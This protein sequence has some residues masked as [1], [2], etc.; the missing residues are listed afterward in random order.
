[1]IVKIYIDDSRVVKMLI[2]EWMGELKD[3]EKEI[4][5]LE[6]NN[7]ED[8]WDKN[9]E[10]PIQSIKRGA[11]FF[12]LSVLTRIAFEM[13]TILQIIRRNNVV[14]TK[15]IDVLLICIDFLNSYFKR[16]YKKLQDISLSDDT[17]SKYFEFETN[18]K[19]SKLLNQIEEFY[20]NY[21]KENETERISIEAENGEIP[22]FSENIAD[23]L[24]INIK[25]QF[26]LENTEHIQE[27]ESNILIRLDSNEN[28]S[29]AIHEIFRI[30][31]SIKG[32]IGVYLS[33]LLPDNKHYNYLKNSKDV[34]HSF[35]N[36]LSLVREKKSNF[37]KNLI[38]LSL[39]V[40]DFMKLLINAILND[41]ISV[42]IDR[43][44]IDKI[45]DE[46]HYIQSLPVSLDKNNNT[47]S[48]ANEVGKAE[49]SKV[50]SNITQSIRVQQEK[51]DA[52]MNI[53]SE[54]VIAK[55][56]FAHISDKL[57][58]E[59]N[60]PEISKEINQLGSYVNRISD[61][62]Q[63][64]IMSIRMVEVKTVFQ[65][66][67][68]IIRDIAQNSGKKIDLIMEGEDTEIDKT[69]IEQISDPLV[70]IIRNSADHGI[71][72]SIERTKKNKSEIGKVIL[73]AY[74]KDKYVF[75]EVEDDGK[76]INP[77]DIKL[78]AIEK[79]IIT[80]YEGD[81]MTD[82]QII[83]LI[84]VPGFSTAKKITE[85]SGRGVGMDIVK[86]NIAKIKGTV[87][88]ESKVDKGAKMII[89]L[90]LSLAVSRGLMVEV[91]QKSYIIPIDN[92]VE[93]VKIGRNNIHK[94]KN[95][96]FTYLR[97]K[98][99][100]LEWLSQMFLLGEIDRDKDEYNAVIISNGLEDYAIIV[101]KLKNEQE[102]VMK[103][104][105]GHLSAIPGISGSTLLG[106]GQVVLILNPMDIINLS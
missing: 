103:P 30:A 98:V 69:I 1:M 22:F 46:I 64:S 34:I 31:H 52:M 67:P 16:L 78:N 8:D 71:E 40:I 80:E 32:S 6:I 45:N 55:N 41:N 91:N 73:R 94:F 75:I 23:G 83:N 17:N 76:G 42:E 62:L 2:K 26:I 104:L 102:F 95:K 13:E 51:I 100:G 43:G 59:Y 84:F 11:S 97:E 81:R 68:R 48:I 92:V 61:E 20:R 82:S 93:T 88:V 79:G 50:K 38:D 21:V 18:L 56:S 57:N 14:E 9:L 54:L 106:N 39:S 35:E 37:G 19:E 4:L 27:L 47:S 15:E 7:Q 105:D 65:K 60:L 101:D 86:S 36:L 44:I 12:G 3:L 29:E 58:K 33:T 99:I 96:Y 87:T 85:V 70:H 72:T 89:R 25:E 66:I 28:D 49:N 5:K 53:I 77:Q 63:N 90:P 74:N 24:E 10:R